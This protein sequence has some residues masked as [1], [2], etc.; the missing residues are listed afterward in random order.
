M[1]FFLEFLVQNITLEYITLHILL[2]NYLEILRASQPTT[3]DRVVWILSDRLVVPSVRWHE[4]CMNRGL[5]Q[6]LH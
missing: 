5:A 2:E 3:T 6:A 1:K 4:S